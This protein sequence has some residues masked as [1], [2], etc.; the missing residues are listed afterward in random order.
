MQK[1]C[2]QSFVD[3]NLCH[4]SLVSMQALQMEQDASGSGGAVIA[5]EVLQ[6][7]ETVLQ[8][9]TNS[10]PLTEGEKSQL[11]MLLDKIPTPFV[12][13]QTLLLLEILMWNDQFYI[14]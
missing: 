10:K 7:M 6:I 12:V 9:A 3:E 5:E 14:H 1:N 4:D 13:K 2:S 8:E 11:D